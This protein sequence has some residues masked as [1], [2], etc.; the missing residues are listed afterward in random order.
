AAL[1]AQQPVVRL[2]AFAAAVDDLPDV[3]VGYAVDAAAAARARQVHARAIVGVGGLAARHP[4]GTD[5]DDAVAGSHGVG[6]GHGIVVARGDHDDGTEGVHLV[7]GVLVDRRACRRIDAAKA[8]VEHFGRVFID[9]H[10]VDRAAGSPDHAVGDVAG[11][12]AAGAQ[13]ADRHHLRTVRKARVAD[14]VV[15]FLGNRAGNMGAVPGAGVGRMRAGAQLGA[16]VLLDPVALVP[17]ARH[18]VVT[19]AARD[20]PVADHVVAGDHVRMQ[21][22][23]VLD[24]AGVDDRDH[25]AL[26]GGDVPAFLGANSADRIM[27]VPLVLLVI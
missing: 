13:D 4:G 25:H 14:C 21:V 20:P 22:E 5:A 1:A 17:A 24:N 12:A 11:E 18:A 6:V 26:A 15:G 7:D 8:H 16:V 19:V 23:G 27:E 10:A 2:R 9:R 3:A